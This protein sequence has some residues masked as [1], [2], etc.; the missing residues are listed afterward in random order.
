MMIPTSK[1]KWLTRISGVVLGVVIAIGSAGMGAR[2]D[3]DD[4]DVLPD[5]KVFRYLMERL[6]LRKGSDG[7]DY[8][9]RSPLVVPPS[10]DLPPPVANVQRESNPAWPKDPDRKP[11][12]AKE[13]PNEERNPPMLGRPLP[14]DQLRRGPRVASGSGAGSYGRIDPEKPLMPSQ[15]GYRGGL[16][17]SLFNAKEGEYSTFTGE[18]PRTSLIQPPPGYQTPSPTQPYGV[19]QERAST[20]PVDRHVPIR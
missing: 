2:A 10:R 12:K 17:N 20:Q 15:L 1:R 11:R 13:N 9:E 6:G 16:F 3:E 14:P 18:A 19:G 4:D 8:R 5:T 7:I